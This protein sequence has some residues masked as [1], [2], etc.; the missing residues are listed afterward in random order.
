[1]NEGA[2]GLRSSLKARVCEAFCAQSRVNIL[3]N[4][5]KRSLATRCLMLMFAE[6]LDWA[7]ESVGIHRLAFIQPAEGLVDLF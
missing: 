4:W 2:K 6:I 5:P 1:M 7:G 3:Q